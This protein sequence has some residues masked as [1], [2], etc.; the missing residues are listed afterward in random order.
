MKTREVEKLCE[1]FGCRAETVF[2]RGAF[3]G[4]KIYA[5]VPG[6]RSRELTLRRLVAKAGNKY[7]SCKEPMDKLIETCKAVRAA[8]DN[9]A[10]QLA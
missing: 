4:W 2:R 3:V 1:L 10:A 7:V 8:V 9:A 6:G 5:V